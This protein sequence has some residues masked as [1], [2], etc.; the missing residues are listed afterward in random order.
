MD[1]CDPGTLR[2]LCRRI[3]AARRRPVAVAIKR[4][5]VFEEERAARVEVELVAERLSRLQRV[6][7][8]LSADLGHPEVVADVLAALTPDLGPGIAVATM[9]QRDGPELRLVL[10]LRAGVHTTDDFESI[11][12]DAPSSRAATAARERVS[13]WIESRPGARC[14]IPRPRRQAI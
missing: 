14:P 12:L 1:S 13:I 3:A 2:Q 4:A 9:W 7:A 6:T 10:L 5:N 11:P 8:A